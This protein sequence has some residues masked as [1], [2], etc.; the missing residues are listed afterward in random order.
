MFHVAKLYIIFHSGRNLHPPN[1]V[2]LSSQI[3]QTSREE[4][5]RK[6]SKVNGK[7]R[8]QVQSSSRFMV[9]CCAD[10]GYDHLDS[11]RVEKA[12]EKSKDKDAPYSSYAQLTPLKDYCEKVRLN[13]KL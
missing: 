1:W 7:G 10:R 9:I 3:F 4:S 11:E 5:P 2:W 8:K 13:N 6:M 12:K